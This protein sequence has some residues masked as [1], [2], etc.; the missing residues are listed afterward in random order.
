MELMGCPCCGGAAA[1]ETRPEAYGLMWGVSV[2]CT[3]CGLRTAPVMY[4]NTGKLV[5]TYP[6]REGRREAELTAKLR[7]Q[8]RDPSSPA[9]AAAAAPSRA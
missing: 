5:D 9:S 7:W 2:H 3:R 1:L 6:S 8:R 4:G